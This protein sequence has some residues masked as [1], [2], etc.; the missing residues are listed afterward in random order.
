MNLTNEAAYLYVQSKRLNRI[1]SQLKKL[2][3]KAEKHKIR[4]H[5]ATK[6]HKKEKHR[7]KHLDA[8]TDIHDLMKEHNKLIQHLQ[9][10]SAAFLSALRK[11]HKI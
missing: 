8:T 11:Q 10:H 5:S 4:Y 9:H 1:N 7:K 6:D 2:T 3:K